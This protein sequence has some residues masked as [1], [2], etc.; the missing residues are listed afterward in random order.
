VTEPWL[1]GLVAC[2]LSVDA[3]A[4]R[5]ALHARGL[6]TRSVPA[7]RAKAAWTCVTDRGTLAVVVSG[8]GVDA[9]RQAASFWMPRT[10]WLVVA[11]AGPGTGL[12]EPGAVV[13]DGDHELAIL[14][15]R[16]A[17][18][19]APVPEA[20]VATVAEAAL[21]EAA[22]A[23][24]KAAG[25]AAW[26]PNIDTW[27]QAAQAVDGVTLVCHGLTAD[28]TPPNPQ[29]PSP[30]PP[31]PPVLASDIAPGATARPWWRQALALLNPRIRAEQRAADQ[32]H[33][34]AIRRAA[35]CAVAA[36]LGR[37]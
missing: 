30:V 33:A 6:R 5:T 26:D 4:V 20:K 37:P 36:L 27:R 23:T 7:G 3:E 2:S 22:R 35:D 21:G 8:R 10:R 29:A 1:S 12:V 14:A 9:A 11:T 17:P 34:Q 24:L 28:A 15:S 19:D 31:K 32:A 13:L 18:P 16:G 25:F